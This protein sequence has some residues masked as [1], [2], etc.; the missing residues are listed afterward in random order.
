MFRYFILLFLLFASL[1]VVVFAF[2]R[3]RHTNQRLTELWS[4]WEEVW[5][6]LHSGFEMDPPYFGVTTRTL[7]FREVFGSWTFCFFENCWWRWFV[8]SGIK[9]QGKTNIKEMF[10]T[11]KKKFSWLKITCKPI[12]NIV[13]RYKVLSRWSEQR[14]VRTITQTVT[15]FISLF[16]TNSPSKQCSKKYS[17]SIIP[18]A[19]FV[20]FGIM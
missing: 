8:N 20:I 17:K 19:F 12:L 11:D 1:T 6:E 13:W 18:L 9:I 7:W 4:G 14:F 15:T 10:E 3:T 2:F 5:I 16:W